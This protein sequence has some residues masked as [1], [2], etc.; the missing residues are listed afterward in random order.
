MLA[1]AHY[2]MTA[3]IL[4]QSAWRN[5]LHEDTS[6]GQVTSDRY[7]VQYQDNYQAGR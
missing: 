6:W 4:W 5:L 2:E 1:V 7:R 3:C